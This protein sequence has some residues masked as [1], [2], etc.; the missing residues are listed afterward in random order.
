MKNSS[1]IPAFEDGT[2]KSVLKRWHIKFR[3]RGITQNKAYNICIIVTTLNSTG[4]LLML[5]LRIGEVL[6][7]SPET[8]LAD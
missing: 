3:R 4:K 5:H 2:D 7:L 8:H 6:G 1:Y